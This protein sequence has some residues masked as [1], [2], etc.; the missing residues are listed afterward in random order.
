MILSN[1]EL[2]VL[3]AIESNDIEALEAIESDFNNAAYDISDDIKNR[4]YVA[5]ESLKNTSLNVSTDKK[6]DLEKNALN[7]TRLINKFSSKYTKEIDYII[8]MY[9]ENMI[10]ELMTLSC[11]KTSERI[12]CAVAYLIDDSSIKKE[13]TLNSNAFDVLK[14]N[15]TLSVDT[16]SFKTVKDKSRANKLLKAYIFLKLVSVENKQYRATLKSDDVITSL[17]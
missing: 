9:D 14:K 1:E 2:A 12:L 16:F 8:N 5:L 10:S 13:R 15:K 4:A 11:Y 7:R 3:N 17:V 6:A